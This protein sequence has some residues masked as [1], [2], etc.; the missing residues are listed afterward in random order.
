M[1]VWIVVTGSC[2][3][4]SEAPDSQGEG[5]DEETA[6][7]DETPP[8]RPRGAD[9]NAAADVDLLRGRLR[10]RIAGRE[11][12]VV[13]GRVDHPDG[14]HWTEEQRFT[15][16]CGLLA[17]TAEESL[18]RAPA[19]L[20]AAVSAEE[21]TEERTIVIDAM[22]DARAPLR[23]VRVLKH[24]DVE[25]EGRFFEARLY[26]A[27]A[28]R[29]VVELGLTCEENSMSAAEW[30]A[31]TK[32]FVASLVTGARRTTFAAAQRTV[33]LGG[34]AV[35]VQVPEGWAVVGRRDEDESAYLVTQVVELGRPPAVLAIVASSSCEDDP[36]GRVVAEANGVEGP[37]HRVE[38][39]IAAR[40]V[41]WFSDRNERS[42]FV[43][44]RRSAASCLDWSIEAP[45]ASGVG[46][47]R[48]IA[49]T[50][51]IRDGSTPND[52]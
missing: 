21:T 28:D 26:V 11:E 49:E 46:A 9:V 6:E 1:A 36:D 17:L 39:R 23:V 3:C 19:D 13:G 27:L 38:G 16:A 14:E 40:P 8:P 10:G 34:T 4:E 25:T 29:T 44:Q 50:A 30:D 18:T 15:A 7:I 31:L 37:L 22:P 43:R 51:T 5:E 45:D 35:T 52:P 20:D 32:P 2:R 42:L 24:D 33:E 47:A 48:R 41:S 12:R